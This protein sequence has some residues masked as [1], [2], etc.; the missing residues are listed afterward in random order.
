MRIPHDMLVLVTDGRKMLLFR[1]AG[2]AETL[3]LEA[4]E[5]A[6]DENPPDREQKSDRPGRTAMMGA[7]SRRS[8]YAESDFHDREE[9]AFARR[10]VEALEGQLERGAF[11]RV[12]I[13]ADPRT[14]GEMRGHYGKALLERLAG[15][16]AKDLVKH[17]VGEIER[18][19]LN[20]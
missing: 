16:V 18:I 4:L 10:A 14:L 13:V 19:L 3:A 1:N 15:E 6:V 8:A 12:L 5:K 2:G 9:K 7:A 17:P 11:E 20:S